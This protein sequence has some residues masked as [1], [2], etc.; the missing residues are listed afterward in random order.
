M[1][2]S[3]RSRFRQGNKVWIRLRLQWTSRVVT[4]FEIEEMFLF[5]SDA[6]NIYYQRYLVGQIRTFYGIQ[7]TIRLNN[8]ALFTMQI[9]M[10]FNDIIDY[11]RSAFD[12][13][14]LMNDGAPLNQNIR[15]HIS[16]EDNYEP[17]NVLSGTV[18]FR[19]GFE[20]LSSNTDT[21]VVHF[22]D[23]FQNE[24]SAEEERRRR[25]EEA[26]RRREEEEEERR[27]QQEQDEI[28]EQNQQNEQQNERRQELVRRIDLLRSQLSDLRYELNQ[29]I[30]LLRSL[31][32]PKRRFSRDLINLRN[33][34]EANQR[35]I[36][37]KITAG[38]RQLRGLL[39]LLHDEIE[40]DNTYDGDTEQYNFSDYEDL[41]NSPFSLPPDLPETD[42]ED[43]NNFLNWLDTNS[44]H[45]FHSLSSQPTDTETELINSDELRQYELQQEINEINNEIRNYQYE[46][47][48]LQDTL[49]DLRSRKVK[50]NKDYRQIIKDIE[51]EI[52]RYRKEIQRCE[53]LLRSMR[54]YA[55]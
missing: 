12:Y 1:D 51:N 43:F 38:E 10:N 6:W 32:I 27:R 37:R 31:Q 2:I 49:R 11:I 41:Q 23:Y 54:R 19:I 9:N 25:E 46:I 55:L 44:E 8:G 45:S 17:E 24:L 34:V 15:F 33:E 7:G 5:T 26:E 28:D 30:D 36:K 39:R 50:R 21:P 29:N 20:L 47:N 14:S 13:L 35:D 53:R 22:R 42:D 16:G 40:L 52:S 4:N 18:D 3:I 48:M